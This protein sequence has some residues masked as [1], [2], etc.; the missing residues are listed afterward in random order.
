MEKCGPM[1]DRSKFY[2][3]ALLLGGNEISLFELKQLQRATQEQKIPLLV[4]SF[5]RIKNN[6][7]SCLFLS[8]VNPNTVQKEK[9]ENKLQNY[10][11]DIVVKEVTLKKGQ[12]HTKTK[13]N[14]SN[15]FMFIE[16][17]HPNGVAQSLKCAKDLLH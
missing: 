10:I 1:A 5:D 17:D 8:D 16:F 12:K 6:T 2:L 14:K 4:D 7:D 3:K 11:K 13:A 9:V 15:T